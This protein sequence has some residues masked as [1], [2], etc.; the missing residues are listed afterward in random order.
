MAEEFTGW[1]QSWGP[2]KQDHSGSKVS[3]CE[4]GAVLDADIQKPSEG[5]GYKPG[6]EKSRLLVL[7]VFPL[8]H[9]RGKNSGPNPAN[10]DGCGSTPAGASEGKSEHARKR[11][12]WTKE[13]KVLTRPPWVPCFHSPRGCTHPDSSTPLGP[14]CPAW[15]GRACGLRVARRLRPEPH[16]GPREALGHITHPRA[17]SVFSAL[18]LGNVPHTFRLPVP[19]LARSARSPARWHTAFT[20]VA[21]KKAELY[22]G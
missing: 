20:A 1:C 13:H 3:G 4:K 21:D 16:A 2:N 10:S 12:R 14:G 5:L 6:A 22:Y 17:R 9:L 15:E 19:V 8:T 7:P 11:G 18:S